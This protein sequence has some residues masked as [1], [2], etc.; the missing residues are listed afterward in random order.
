MNTCPKGTDINLCRNR[1]MYMEHNTCTDLYY[2]EKFCPTCEIIGPLETSTSCYICNEKIGDNEQLEQHI[3]DEVGKDFDKSKYHI[4][5]YYFSI[6]K[7]A[8]DGD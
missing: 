4:N 1:D 3:M 7:L 8:T 2:E 6:A 5:C